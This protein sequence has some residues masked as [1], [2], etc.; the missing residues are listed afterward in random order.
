MARSLTG[1][2]FSTLDSKTWQTSEQADEENTPSKT[3]P[4]VTSSYV[5]R[6]WVSHDPMGS[7]W[8]DALW[9]EAR[10]SL[11]VILSGSEILLEDHLGNLLAGQKELLTK[12][13]DNTYHLCN[14]LS[15]LLGPEE[16]K[17]DENSE[18]RS[19]VVRGVPV[20]V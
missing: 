11:Q 5:D 19:K 14:L 15:D 7:T 17:V 12:M 20:K 4:V 6:N 1:S 2:N 18:E 13:I 9:C 3:S 16:F 10:N 8:N